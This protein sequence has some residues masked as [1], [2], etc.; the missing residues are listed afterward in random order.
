[1]APQSVE[2]EQLDPSPRMSAGSAASRA[3]GLT[4]AKIASKEEGIQ[5][6]EATQEADAVGL[7]PDSAE[8]VVV[9]ENVVEIVEIAVAVE[10]G[11][12]RAALRNSVREDASSATRKGTLRETAP[13]AVEV[14]VAAEAV[15]WNVEAETEVETTASVTTTDGLLRGA[16]LLPETA[17]AATVE[18][19]TCQSKDACHPLVE[20]TRNRDRHPGKPASG[21]LASV[22]IAANEGPYTDRRREIEKTNLTKMTND[23]RCSCC[24]RPI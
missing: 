8:V 18:R 21:T 22:S 1:M 24:A 19:G 3:I 9:M 4:T 23:L 15:V 5:G 14:E 12:E 16:D 13:I 11:R 2:E 10:A 6:E 7:H 17:T 20:T